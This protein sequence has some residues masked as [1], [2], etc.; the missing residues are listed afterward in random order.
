MENET[1]FLSSLADSVVAIPTVPSPTT[2]GMIDIMASPLTGISQIF[3]VES[4]LA[5]GVIAAGGIASYSPGL[6]AH[7][8][9]GSAVGALT[10]ACLG[11][12]GSEIASGLWGFNSA[13]TS[14]AVGV[15]FVH[16]TPTMVFSAGGAAATAAVFGAMKEIFGVYG[17]PCL[18]LPFCVT[19]SA[20]YLLHKQIPG[21]MLASDPHSPEKNTSKS[22]GGLSGL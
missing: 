20:C 10:G 3:V 22:K 8:V 2:T 17:S 18:T 1:E 12:P 6:A 15:F 7:A 5:G 13:L 19:M 4:A 21:L 16:S 11:A 9:A 14:M